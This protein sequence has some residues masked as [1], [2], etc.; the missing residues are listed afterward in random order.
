M[1]ALELA[2]LVLGERCPFLEAVW[3][4]VVLVFEQSLSLRF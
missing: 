3:A 2:A 1:S 4:E